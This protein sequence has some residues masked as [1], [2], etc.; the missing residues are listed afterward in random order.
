M[1]R[2]VAARIASTLVAFTAERREGS[3]ALAGEW[4]ASHAQPQRV[5]GGSERHGPTIRRWFTE[6]EESVRSVD[7]RRERPRGT[8]STVFVTGG[9]GQ[10]G[11]NVCE[12]LIEQATR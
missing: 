1:T 5:L 9:T 6:I 11:A 12:Q 3:G 8:M 10:T 2:R 7:G 4:V